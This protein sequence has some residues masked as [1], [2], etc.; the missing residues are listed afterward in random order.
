MACKV[1]KHYRRTRKGKTVVVA[2]VRKTKLTKRKN[3]G[4]YFDN[5]KERERL[6][7][8]KNSDPVGELIQKAKNENRMVIVKGDKLIAGPHRSNF[9]NTQYDLRPMKRTRRKTK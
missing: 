9:L 4:A 8:I 1:S 2:H 3:Y 6:D 5:P 7:R